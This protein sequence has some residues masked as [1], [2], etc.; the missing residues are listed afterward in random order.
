MTVINSGEIVG[1]QAVGV[2]LPGG[3]I[4]T[5][6]NITDAVDGAYTVYLGDVGLVDNSGTISATG[7]AALGAVFT[8]G[9]T[10]TNGG[11]GETTQAVI[12]AT[13]DAVIFTTSGTVTNDG[14]IS[15]SGADGVQFQELSNGTAAS[16]GT[17]T[18]GSSMDSA[19]TIISTSTTGVGVASQGGTITNSGTIE[20]GEYGVETNTNA[21][22]VVNTG[23]ISATDPAGTLTDGSLTIGVSMTAGGNITNG[24]S[25]GTVAGSATISAVD[26]GVDVLNGSSSITNSGTISGTYGI[27]FTG[28]GVVAATGTVDDYGAITSTAGAN[29]TAILFGTGAEKLILEQGFAITGQVIGG[30]A[31]S[32]DTT[33][34]EVATGTTGTFSGVGSGSGS[35]INGDGSSTN[36]FAFS[37]VQTI[38]IDSSA[39]WAFSGVNAV[40]TLRVDGSAQVLAGGSLATTLDPANETGTLSVGAGAVLELLAATGAGNAI[41]VAAGGILKI[42]A[43][44]SFGTGS[45]ST[46]TGDVVGLVRGTGGGSIDLANV[47]FTSQTASFNATTNL[48]TVSDG[49]NTANISFVP[50]LFSTIGNFVLTTDGSGGTLISVPCF[51]PGTRIAT[52]DGEIEIEKLAIGDMVTMMDG[53]AEPIRW[54]GRRTYAGRFLAANPKVHPIRFRKGSLG[55]GLPRRDLL[56]SPEHAMFINGALIPARCLVNCSLIVVDSGLKAVDYIHIEFA[57]HEVVL[58]EGAA[59]E[60][61]VDD[62]SRAMFHNASEYAELYPNSPAAVGYYADRMEGGFEVEALRAKLAKIADKA[63]NRRRSR[64]LKAA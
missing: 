24:P 25:N 3:S 37:N 39:S 15:S 50:G 41:D 28:N 30:S 22:Q 1:T 2:N 36:G 12:S 61:F 7:G 4:Y 58:A 42:D 8:N 10:L 63:A 13:Y 55:K 23:T 9:G 11:F 29:G 14:A 19:A 18:N 52:P 17:V 16:V 43:A 34:I 45:G 5:A 38:D 51:C 62:D 60:S 31:T 53:R 20:G 49:T 57:N 47:A 44:N 46:Y 40:S 32:S 26:I 35:V 27:A 21:G 54:I 6:G 48:L 64:K 33:T 59:S 56:V